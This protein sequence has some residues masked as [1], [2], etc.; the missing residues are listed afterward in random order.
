MRKKPS[1]QIDSASEVDRYLSVISDEQ[2]EIFWQDPKNGERFTRLKVLHAMHH[3]IPVSSHI[4]S[5]GK[6]L[7]CCWV[8]C[9]YKAQ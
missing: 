8:H 2:V 1:S 6:N 4:R 5:H 3:C 9:E 7:Q